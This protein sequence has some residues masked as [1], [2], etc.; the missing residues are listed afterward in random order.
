MHPPRTFHFTSVTAFTLA[1]VMMATVV[2]LV[3]IVGLVRAITIGAEMLDVSR[4]QTVAVLLIRNEI[5]NVHLKD[6]ATV[7]AISSPSTIT[8]NGAGTS[9]SG[10]VT[11][12]ALTN[13][14]ALTTDDNTTLM[15]QAKGFTFTLTIATVK[16]NMLQLTY[17]VGWTG[18]NRRKSYTRTGTTYYARYGLNLYYRK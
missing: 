11:A 18:G 17:T 2:T 3:A 15:N 7:S 9:A 4:K 10:S 1:E 6:W 5:D 8:I 14:T 12:F 13:Y 16:A